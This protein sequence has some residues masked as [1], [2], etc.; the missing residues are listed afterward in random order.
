MARGRE[1]LI[2]T[3]EQMLEMFK[4]YVQ[5]VKSNPR[6]K[7]EYVGKDGTKVHT[8]IERPLSLQGF[9]TF[10]ADKYSDVHHYFENTD[11]RYEDFRG[12][13]TRIS[14]AI[15]AEQIDGGMTGFYS[16]NLTA[17]LTGLADKQEIKKEPE[18][19]PMFGDNPLKG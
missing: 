1:K 14:N 13:C 18:P 10:C 11:K 2:K 6:M 19:K 9:Y 3:P 16:A 15:K 7:Y 4:E 5:E 8:P 17:R 12:I